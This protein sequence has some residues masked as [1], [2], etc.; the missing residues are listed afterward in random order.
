MLQPKRTK[1]RKQMKGRMKGDAGRGNQLAYGT[2]GIKSLESEFL[3]ARQIEA[4]RIAA[5]RFMKREGSIWIMIFPDKPITKKP[6]EVR[7]GKGKGAVEYYA[8]V[9]KP[10]RMLFEVSG[11]TLETAKE[12]LRLAAQKLPVKTKFVMSRDFQA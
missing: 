1:Y 11:V 3:T 10:G 7:M 9:V 5:T 2:F 4:A 12:A 6:L 8:A